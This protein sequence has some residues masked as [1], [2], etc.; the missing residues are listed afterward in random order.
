MAGCEYTIAGDDRVYSESEFKKLLNEGYL[1]KVM[2]E[3]QVKIRGIKPNEELAKSFTMPSAVKPAVTTEV[4]TEG[5][6]TTPIESTT[7]TKENIVQT[8]VPRKEGY[9]NT[10]VKKEEST[11]PS[12][13][14]VTTYNAYA[15]NESGKETKIGTGILTTVGE[16]APLV[17]GTDGEAIF[18]DEDGNLK[19][20]PNAELYITKTIDGTNQDGSYQ[21]RVTVVGK[22]DLEFNGNLEADFT[23]NKNVVVGESS[24]KSNLTQ[25][26]TAPVE[27]KTEEV[28]TP[29]EPVTKAEEKVTEPTAEVT[30]ETKQPTREETAAKNLADF[31][32]KGK[33]EKGTAMSSL[34]GFEQVWNGTIETVAKAIELGGVTAGNLRQSIEAGMKAF[35]GTDIYKSL[36]PKERAK[37]S[38]Q[39]RKAL[40]E[41]V[42]QFY[43]INTDDLRT[44]EFESFNQKLEES[45]GKELSP[46]EF[47]ALKNEAKKF[48]NDNL[49][50]D[51]FR[52]SEVQSYVRNNFDKAKTVEDIQNN[53]DKVN[54]IIATKEAKIQKE[55]EKKEAKDKKTLIKEIQDKV[56]R[57][58]KK[59][60]S[61][62]RRTGRRTAKI[63]LDAQE[64]LNQLHK[65]GV[66][67]NLDALSQEEL[68]DINDNI[69]NI[70]SQGKADK[71]FEKAI[72]DLRKRTDQAMILEELGGKPEI[73]NG[74]EEILDK[75]TEESGV[76]VIN[77]QSMNKSRFETFV[78]NNPDADLS[79]VKFYPN[80][81]SNV[82]QLKDR[83]Q[84][85]YKKAKATTLMALRDLETAV[86]TLQKGSAKMRNWLE[87]S[88]MKPIREAEYNKQ[89]FIH[90]VNLE[91]NNKLKEIFG[92][93]Q[94]KGMNVVSLAPYVLNASSTVSAGKTSLKSMQLDNLT[95]AQVIQFYGLIT[96]QDASLTELSENKKAN[97]ELLKKYNK[98][99]PQAIIDYM[100]DPKNKKL[101]DYYNYLAETYNG[102]FADEFIP[103]I[104]KLYGVAIEKGN[105]WP[106][107][108]S[109]AGTDVG[110]LLNLEGGN[111]SNIS[112]IAPQMKART[113]G[114]HPFEVLSATEMFNRYMESMAHA[115]EFLP[116][117][118]NVFSLLSKNNIPHIINKFG[119]INKYN[120]FIEDLNIVLTDKKPFLNHWS[121]T[122][123]NTN[124]LTTL[125]FRPKSILQQAISG[126]HFYHSGIK[127][128]VYPHDV[129]AA[130]LPIN[131]EE[132]AFLKDF[133]SS[134]NSYLWT[135]FTGGMTTQDTQAVRLQLDRLLEKTFKQGS[136]VNQFVKDFTK[137]IVNTGMSGIKLGDFL[138]ASAPGAG[139]NFA[140]AQFRN[141]K[142]N[143][144]DFES[145]KREA[146]QRWF[147][148]S[149][150]VLQPSIARETISS[151]TYDPFYRIFFPFSSANNAMMKKVYKGA[152]NLSDWKNLSNKERTQSATDILY[153]SLFAGLP[154]ALIS[155]GGLLAWAAL[156]DEEDENLAE[157][158][159]K[160]IAFDAA[161]ENIQSNIGT[162]GLL[163]MV[164]KSYMNTQRGKEFY[165]NIPFL[166]RLMAYTDLLVSL[167]NTEG[168]VSKLSES[169]WKAFLKGYEPTEFEMRKIKKMTPDEA[170]KYFQENPFARDVFYEDVAKEYSELNTIQ[171]M[172]YKG[173][174]ALDK[175]LG[176]KNVKEFVDGF[177]AFIEG[178]ADAQEILFG[179]KARKEEGEKFHPYFKGRKEDKI[180]KST[181]ESYNKFME[182]ETS[183]EEEELGEK[184]KKEKEPRSSAP[185]KFKGP[186]FKPKLP[187]F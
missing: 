136:N 69:D 110:S 150:R 50:S 102:K 145:S 162:L 66:F 126:A 61:T 141:N 109:G 32:R 53:L 97:V 80:E 60:I 164:L 92:A 64:Q 88:L 139:M 120:K 178:D 10:V 39:Y 149:E 84:S 129:L 47:T 14:K 112:V 63:S 172:D 19:E 42:P 161:V 100:N 105:Y 54:N 31:L 48:V 35:K 159:K 148:E 73:L 82:D 87:N 75:L 8:Q 101:L 186:N 106:E 153:Y 5:E 166:E 51:K 65:Q 111:S 163:G 79:N 137:V 44:G 118:E 156:N 2:L 43:N 3:N 62:N 127:D 179:V 57:N 76:V 168:D 67:N 146:M 185:G 41:K 107:P 169:E 122:M 70:L 16:I 180:Y 52:K 177:G 95:N 30:P 119:D 175:I 21:Q 78:E 124:A 113:G 22:G 86:L 81:Y 116:I 114:N 58:S 135:R 27:V 1:D 49:P 96:N 11:T 152:L 45:K 77:N 85:S 46:K 33:M 91:H 34:P 171:K 23:T 182:E 158:Q 38:S 134:D 108:K 157:A 56:K 6:V 165:N 123:A 104:E 29:E 7:E 184:E 37:M 17:K 90:R 89:D 24:Y 117:V 36:D 20:D 170:E 25:E 59:I 28:V 132:L 187:K 142:S 99:D 181:I 151:A 154:F 115:K 131:K 72:D 143:G 130:S 174:R 176:T 18:Y 26:K 98:V 147:E 13:D 55:T 15:V 40:L 167:S 93:V 103:M 125:W 68:N 83:L 160:R 155:S 183:P 12:G 144:N 121:S 173:K 133:F 128:G 140:L 74:E 138:S 71:K 4:K 9:Q 94:V